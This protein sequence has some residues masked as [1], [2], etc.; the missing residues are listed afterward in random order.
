[1]PAPGVTQI[2]LP[3]PPVWLEVDFDAPA[4]AVIWPAR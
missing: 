3:G 2:P 1:V 4:G